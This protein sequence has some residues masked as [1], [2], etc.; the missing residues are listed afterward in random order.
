MENF[1][2][3]NVKASLDTEKWIIAQK[4]DIVNGSSNYISSCETWRKRGRSPGHLGQLLI[5]SQLLR[6]WFFFFFFA[7]ITWLGIDILCHCSRPVSTKHHRVNSFLINIKIHFAC[8]EVHATRSTIRKKSLNWIQFSIDGRFVSHPEPWMSC[9][10]SKKV[11]QGYFVLYWGGELYIWGDKRLGKCEE[12]MLWNT[13][14]HLSPIYRWCFYLSK[15]LL[16]L[17]FEDITYRAFILYVDKVIPIITNLFMIN[18]Y[19]AVM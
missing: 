10:S 19:I 5:N 15:A 6:M 2:W 11:S 18:F 7:W 14:H 17:S 9:R 4:H 3:I 12:R 13:Q 16:M 8:S 1:V